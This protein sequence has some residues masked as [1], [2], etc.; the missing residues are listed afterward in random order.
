MCTSTA[1]STSVAPEEEWSRSYG[2]EGT[3]EGR[4]YYTIWACQEVEDGGYILAGDV[5]NDDQSDK[6]VDF[7]L[8]KTDSAGN[9]EWNK[10]F[11]GAEL[12]SAYSARQTRDGGYILAGYSE[13]NGMNGWV[14][15]T[16]SEGEEEWNKTFGGQR[17]DDLKHVE[18]TSDGGYIFAGRTDSFGAGES[19]A[20]LI[21]TDSNGNEEWSRTFGGTS[22]E[23]AYY[24]QETTNG[25]YILVCGTPT[26]V[27]S[28]DTHTAF[29][30]KT[31]S[32]GNEEWNRS[33]DNMGYDYIS[34][35][36]ETVDGGYILAGIT[37]PSGNYKAGNAWLIKTNQDGEEEWSRTFENMAYSI[38]LDSIQ[39]T[40]DGGYIFAILSSLIKTDPT[41]YEEWNK[42]FENTGDITFINSIQ[43]TRDKGYILAGS[44]E[45][46]SRACLIKLAGEKDPEDTLLE[47]KELKDYVSNLENVDDSTKN[48]L[49]VK[50]E[51]AVRNLEKGKAEKAVSKLEQFTDS[52]D[53]L[54]LQNKISADQANILVH[55]TQGIIELIEN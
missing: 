23:R 54:S 36:K 9:E 14:V 13:T 5:I 7:V 29:L 35:A 4:Y 25:E 6:Y 55:E 27:S 33:F 28:I 3:A 46:D 48:V 51:N 44:R 49:T 20:W 21:K 8:I 37:R 40:N 11:G 19:D 22:N 12:Q 52:V 53:K 17:M 32:S 50:L 39:Q 38:G 10:T 15:K 47:V 1:L 30:I 2:K 31:D 45:A 42:T 43:K 24:V 16:D 26:Y 34:S 41:G 18:E